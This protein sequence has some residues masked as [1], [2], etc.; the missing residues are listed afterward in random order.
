MKTV[1]P[2]KGRLSGLAVDIL[3]VCEL[4]C[5]SCNASVPSAFETISAQC[6][7]VVWLLPHG[8][9]EEG[10]FSHDEINMMTDT[11]PPPGM[12]PKGLPTYY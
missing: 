8:L 1:R 6:R 3:S 11:I 2:R 9:V 5:D 4:P 10:V 12:I 7:A